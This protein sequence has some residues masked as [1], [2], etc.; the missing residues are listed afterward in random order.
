MNP[1]G[2]TETYHLEC[3][4]RA[5]CTFRFLRNVVNAQPRLV[6]SH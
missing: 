5:F 2:K 1:A 4:F 3:M 6:V